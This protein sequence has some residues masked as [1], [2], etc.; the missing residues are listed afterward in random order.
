M[1][2]K[3]IR[4]PRKKKEKR[5][6]LT[7]EEMLR[8]EMFGKEKTIILKDKDLLRSKIDKLELQRQL[9][10]KDIEL[11]G[12]KILKLDENLLKVTNKSSEFVKDLVKE[13][14]VKSSKFGYD[15]DTGEVI[16][17]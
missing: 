2:E 6:H 15:P 12:S 5:T 14:E 17:D 7:S 13:L 1:E 16:E 4:K 11:L 3:K 10:S 9:L 8:I